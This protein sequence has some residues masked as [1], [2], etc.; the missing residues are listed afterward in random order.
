MAAPQT[1]MQAAREYRAAPL[2]PQ[3]RQA[4][5]EALRAAI[6]EQH[7][8]FDQL[9]QYTGTSEPELR[10]LLDSAGL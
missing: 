7:S 3:R 9:L 5:V 1:L 10:N 2:S 4:L 8:T 6:D